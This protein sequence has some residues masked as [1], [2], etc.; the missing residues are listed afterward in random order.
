VADLQSGFD[1]AASKLP[2]RENAS[3]EITESDG[4]LRGLSNTQRF[5]I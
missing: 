1:W 3:L 4:W 2:Q 5:H